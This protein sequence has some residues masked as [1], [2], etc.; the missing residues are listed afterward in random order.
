TISTDNLAP[1]VDTL[2]ELYD[3]DSR[4]LLDT[5]DNGNGGLASQLTWRAES[6]GIYFIRIVR[7]PAGEYGCSASYSLSLM[8]ERHIFLPLI[9]K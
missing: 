6:S 4:T 1:G 8:Q 5:D 3:Q 2:V 7:P 9:Q